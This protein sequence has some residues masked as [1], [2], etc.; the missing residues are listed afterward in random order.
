MQVVSVRFAGDP[1]IDPSKLPRRYRR[2]NLY[3]SAN[4]LPASVEFSG[5]PQFVVGRKSQRGV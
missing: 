5:R 2:K 1:V 4:S 3:R